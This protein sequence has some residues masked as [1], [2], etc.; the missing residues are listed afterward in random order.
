M[1]QEVAERQ[2]DN[3]QMENH[4]YDC[5]YNHHKQVHP[6]GRQTICYQTL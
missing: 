3:G 1:R 2:K 5:I 4:L 6:T